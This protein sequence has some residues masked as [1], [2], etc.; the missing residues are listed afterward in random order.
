M[1]TRYHAHVFDPLEVG[2]QNSASVASCTGWFYHDVEPTTRCIYE[3]VP[4]ARAGAH[5]DCASY[6]R[7]P[8]ARELADALRRVMGERTCASGT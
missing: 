1:R 6:Q 5:R 8:T 4:G 7:E 2:G 3:R